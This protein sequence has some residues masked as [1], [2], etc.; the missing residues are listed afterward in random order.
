MAKA[1]PQDVVDQAWERSGGRCECT[2]SSHPHGAKR[3]PKKLNKGSRGKESEMGWEA[4]HIVT[5]GPATLSNC[6][7][8]CME[9]HK[10]TRSYGG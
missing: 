7:I 10:L 1:F 5:T 2:R 3:C 6:Q 9:C 4:H 8:L